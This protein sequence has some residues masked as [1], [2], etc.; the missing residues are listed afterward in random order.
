MRK[1]VKYKLNFKNKKIV[2]FRMSNIFVM[3]NTDS[4]KNVLGMNYEKN[5]DTNPE[6]SKTFF[7]NNDTI[8]TFFDNVAES[9][10]SLPS[11]SSNSDTESNISSAELREIEE[12]ME[13]YV[14]K[15]NRLCSISEETNK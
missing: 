8:A 13:K 9:L 3:N 1:G 10:K 5:S 11:I 2:L 7:E 14:E 15:S 12:F 4:K 6:I